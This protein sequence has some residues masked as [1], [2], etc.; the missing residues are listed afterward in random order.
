[1]QFIRPLAVLAL[2][3]GL[4]ACETP[5]AQ[6]PIDISASRASGARDS[7]D[8]SSWDT[9]GN[10][11]VCIKRVPASGNA[12][13]KAGERIIAK[14]DDGNGVCPGGFAPE[15]I[16]QA[17]DI[18]TGALHACMVDSEGIAWCWGRNSDGQLG[19]P[20]VTES[21]VPVRVETQVRFKEIDAGR[22][23]T[24][25]LSVEGVVYC[26]GDNRGGQLGDGTTVS[27]PVPIPVLGAG[28][29][30]T[31]DAGPVH[32]CAIAPNGVAH[33]W[34]AND[35]RAGGRFGGLGSVTSET[36]HDPSY[37]ADYE[38]PCS[39]APRPVD[40]SLRFE[41]IS[42]GFLDT[43]AMATDGEA[44]CW[45][46]DQWHQGG[47]GS[48]VTG[49]VPTAVATPPD[50]VTIVAGTVTT[51]GLDQTGSA[52]CWG[53]WPIY[54]GQTGYGEIRRG[55]A[56]P[57]PVVGGHKFSWVGSSDANDIFQF[58]CGIDENG[59][60]WCRGSNSFGQ[61]GTDDPMSDSCTAFGRSDGCTA[62]PVLVEG[63]LTWDKIE[64]GREYACGLATGGVPYC[65]GWNSAGNL[66]DGTKTDH[67]LPA[68]VLL[69]WN[70][71]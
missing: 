37:L 61:L 47:D 2:I 11:I 52:F 18:A 59:N 67:T 34:G 7:I 48:S 31:L 50:L 9:N 43:C 63:G 46:W 1:M 6:T 10:S 19:T 54:F 39:T 24:C 56:T 16:A 53:T 42:A 20:V 13:S 62:V 55:E 40:T 66:G 15:R 41:S 23:H 51:C 71:D 44:Y 17:A 28:T 33:C 3:V 29:F 30:E 8:E 69:P 45:G 49:P 38:I 32:T 25:A 60:A 4:A 70:A 65:W 26:W 64:P 27:R 12:S 58:T 36:C 68:P 22:L 35:W 14:D 57:T 21:T 5:T